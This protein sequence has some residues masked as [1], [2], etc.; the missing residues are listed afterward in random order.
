MIIQSVETYSYIQLVV[1]FQLKREQLNLGFLADK[2]TAGKGSDT[3]PAQGE[4]IPLS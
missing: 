2:G 4:I 3:A 1:Q